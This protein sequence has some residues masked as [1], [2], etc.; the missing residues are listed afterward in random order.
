MRQLPAGGG[1]AAGD[2]GAGGPE[3]AAGHG[4]ETEGGVWWRCCADAFRCFALITQEG[5]TCVMKSPV[6][7]LL[8][9]KSEP[10]SLLPCSSGFSVESS[11][12]QDCLK[13]G[14]STYL[15]PHTASCGTWSRYS[16]LWPLTP[17]C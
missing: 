12:D 4:G 9:W 10:G 11:D 7:Q 16:D 15:S 14:S 2:G 1:A 5:L 17:Q 13:S 3:E 6:N 8:A